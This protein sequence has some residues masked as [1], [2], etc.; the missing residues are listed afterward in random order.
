M[1]FGSITIGLLQ[2]PA[3]AP[4]LPAPEDDALQDAHLAHLAALADEGV[5]L[6]AGPLVDQDDPSLRGVVLLATPVDD[7]REQL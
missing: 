2:R 6:T 4:Q 1:T 7:A 5:L 3:D